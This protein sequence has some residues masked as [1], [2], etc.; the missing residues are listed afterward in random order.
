MIH[1]LKNRT[2]GRRLQSNFA[3]KAV[4]RVSC[5]QVIIP[6]WWK[7]NNVNLFLDLSNIKFTSHIAYYFITVWIYVHI[8]ALLHIPTTHCIWIELNWIE[9]NWTVQIKKNKRICYQYIAYYFITVWIYVH[10]TTLLHIRTTHCIGIE[11]TK[12]YAINMFHT[13]SLL[14]GYGHIIVLLHIHTT[15]CINKEKQKKMLKICCIFLH[16]EL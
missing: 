6:W 2:L 11:K 4:I 7:L 3:G 9:L 16:L 14:Y 10:I 12:E 5:D 1:C 13:A 8:T 15:H